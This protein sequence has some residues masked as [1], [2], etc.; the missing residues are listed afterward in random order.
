M[1]TRTLRSLPGI[2]L[3]KEAE[4]NPVSSTRDHR[5]DDRSMK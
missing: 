4:N 1:L 5:E 2:L 3:H